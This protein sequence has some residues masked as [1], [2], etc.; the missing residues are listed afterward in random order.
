MMED[1][2]TENEWFPFE[3]NSFTFRAIV[4]Q[5]T[6]QAVHNRPST[7][8][9]H[10]HSPSLL[11]FSC[12]GDTSAD[13][14]MGPNMSGNR[15]GGLAGVIHDEEDKENYEPE[16]ELSEQDESGKKQPFQ[17][18][19]IM[20]SEEV[21]I[22]DERLRIAQQWIR[23]NFYEHSTS[24]VC[25]SRLYDKYI[26]FC[27]EHG[28]APMNMATLG[29]HIRIIF[30][31]IITRRLGNRGNSKYH[32]Y[33]LAEM[34]VPIGMNTETPIKRS[35]RQKISKP[36]FK[37]TTIRKSS[38]TK[39]STNYRMSAQQSNSTGGF[40]FFHYPYTMTSF[41]SS[42]PDYSEFSRILSEIC[43]FSVGEPLKLP[44]EQFRSLSSSYQNHAA[45]LL[46]KICE[47]EFSS[48]EEFICGYWK[49]VTEE[50]LEILKNEDGVKLVSIID[51]YL[52]Q[53]AA[54]F[55]I[56]EAI[57]P[58]PLAVLQ[59]IRVFA[60]SVDNWFTTI[61]KTTGLPI[62]FGDNA[63]VPPRV[64]EAKIEVSRRFAQ[65]LR[66][67]TS[68]NHLAQA[69]QSVIN[70]RQQVQQMIHDWDHVDFGTIRDQV[71]SVIG[72][73]EPFVSY[74]EIS[75]KG[76]LMEDAQIAMWTNWL[77][78][79]I[80]QFIAVEMT[81]GKTLDKASRHLILNWSFYLTLILRD[82]TLRSANSF[83]S[84]HIMRLFLE[85][86]AIY[87]VEKKLDEHRRAVGVVSCWTG[88]DEFPQSVDSYS[89]LGY[90]DLIDQN[91]NG[92]LLMSS[93]ADHIEAGPCPQR[94]D[95]GKY[96]ELATILS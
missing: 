31:D 79:L 3:D 65:I 39:T 23:A 86:Y 93:V 84:F 19:T 87:Y 82:L 76:Y 72:I 13:Y 80:E 9:K 95:D 47:K 58:F 51:D 28:H 12:Q 4:C 56:Q 69:M 74:I 75:V 11:S 36:K 37:E 49:S 27:Q 52:Y 35:P 62:I 85:E 33:G 66:R 57:E 77:E 21:G 94:F 83:G 32:Y 14:N 34:G 20:E 38:N 18:S 10:R 8:P 59:S 5:Q 22:T 61:S 63:S 50:D 15:G 67:R 68:V 42:S 17:S 7:N 60:K 43:T 64:I 6:Q 91:K 89:R 24:S 92:L 48:V 96:N 78:N 41:T 90:E 54:S 46:K 70:N 73:K 88:N 45:E 16:S 55:L 44:V 53:V 2:S 26:L 1:I 81:S 30:P 40:T 29:K 25:R 71:K